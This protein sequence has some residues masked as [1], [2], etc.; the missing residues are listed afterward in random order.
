MV[1]RIFFPVGLEKFRVGLKPCIPPFDQRLAFTP[2][3]E[4]SPEVSASDPEIL[5]SDG[6][7]GVS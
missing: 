1:F 2:T 6:D 4:H 7:A 3:V 5:S